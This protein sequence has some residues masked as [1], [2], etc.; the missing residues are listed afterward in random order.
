ML[1]GQV[2]AG[3]HLPGHVSA[4]AGGLRVSRER[5]PFSCK[6]FAIFMICTFI[7]SM[8]IS[9][10]PWV[11]P[12]GGLWL[13]VTWANPPPF[14]QTELHGLDGEIHI[15]RDQ[16]GVP[17]IFATTV[18]DLFLA[19]GYVHAQDRLFEMDLYRR[20]AEGR[21]AEV[22][23][24]ENLDTDLF[25]RQLGL[26]E[27]A[28]ASYAL[29]DPSVQLLLQKYATGV[30]L[31][32]DH[33]GGQVPMEFRVLGY[34]P[35]HWT[36]VDALTMERYVAWLGVEGNALQ[37]LDLFGLADLIK[38][39]PIWQEL[40][41]EIRYDDLPIVPSPNLAQ[42]APQ[43]NGAAAALRE[44]ATALANDWRR[45]SGDSA[46]AADVCGGSNAWVV[47][48]TRSATHAPLLACDLHFALALPALWYEV[49]LVGGGMNV[50]GITFPG[51]PF[52][53]AG[54]NANL[55]WGITAMQSDVSDYYYY[56]WN[57]STSPNQYW[58]NGTWR[59]LTAKTIQLYAKTSGGFAAAPPVTVY[60]TVHGPLFSETQGSFALKWIGANGSRSA[61]GFLEM[62][63]ATDYATFS[64]ALQLLTD[65]DLNVVYADKAGNIAYHAVGAHPIRASG[66]A[67]G[68]LNGSIAANE[69][70]GLIP[71]AEL[72]QSL[73][74]TQG[75][76]VA[77]NNRPSNASY[78]YYLGAGFASA[79]R[80]QR[81][82]QLL[83]AT[84]T[85]SLLTMAAIQLDTYDADAAAMK[86]IV[87]GVVLNNTSPSADPIV[88][89]AATYLQSWDCYATTA[90]I[91]ATVWTS[92]LPKFMNAT[93]L[94]EYT[95]AH[96][97]TTV[98]P[99]VDV[100]ENFTR[101]NY[102]RWFN[103]TTRSGTQTRD[104][105]ILTAF[106][107]A[108]AEL[109]SVVNA[110]PSH[111]Q[112]G[113]VHV[114]WMQ[115]PMS[116]SL[117]FLD[118]PRVPIGGSAYSVNYSPSYLVTVGASWRQLIDLGD[119]NGS[120]GVIAGGQRGNPYSTHY[121]DQL[122]LWL[123]GDYHPLLFP[124]SEAEMA[125]FESILYL[126]PA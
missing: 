79:H 35:E 5:K 107:A 50:R 48:S 36:A 55:A 91:G 18:E 109:V 19:C 56:A 125:K 22:F 15:V 120:R 126:I 71:F 67:L 6:S 95:L 123:A 11:Q 104:D 34:L 38:T 121:L 21:I 87:A 85:Q 65:C 31:Y 33:I 62:A 111:W 66:D 106:D 70:Q 72:P 17:H 99:S 68:P 39:D 60:S 82:T 44:A 83:N 124:S 86:D 105:I 89:A 37:E 43:E 84:L 24:P 102:A 46:L 32:L 97:S 20:I 51:F 54:Y 10:V 63:N 7:L 93:F 3:S 1:E 88:H 41:P 73:N 122:G 23:G 78:P 103:D 100:L 114:L 57:A 49:H 26:V 30:N 118:A 12:N 14:A 40:F 52:V 77:A 101:M 28:T 4:S 42:S 115:H 8:M 119:L 80:A 108:V 76:L 90:S 74:P 47:N 27:A 61:Q 81:I 64:A 98:Y 58:W 13:D 94:D 29:L 59:T 117:P 110:D 69:W 9:I 92:F 53:L 75:F 45:I 96:L 25:H 116:A 112:Y 113:G 2:F 16:W